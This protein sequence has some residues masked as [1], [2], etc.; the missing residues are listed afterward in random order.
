MKTI[1]VVALGPGSPDFLT[2]GAFDALKKSKNLVLRTR[3]HA[4]ADMLKK[5]G[6]AFDT[7][8]SLYDSSEDFDDFVS[9]A[10]DALTK[11]AAKKPLVY[12]VTDPMQDETVSRLIKIG[13]DQ[14]RL[15]PGV[16]L[17]GPLTAACQVVAP[18]VATSATDLV[19]VDAQRPLAVTELNSRLLAGEVKLRL[20]PYYGADAQLLFFPPSKAA[21]RSFVP[22][23]LSDLDRQDK[24]D[25]TAGFVLLPAPLT[26][27]TAFDV[28]DLMRIMRILCGRD[29]CPWDRKQTHLSLIPY[30]IEEA[31]EAAA[32]LAEEDYEQAFDELGDVLLQVA[33][34]ATVG[35][36]QGTMS[37]PDIT[38]AICSKL[39]RR[40]PHVF[41]DVSADTAEKVLVNWENIKKQERGETNTEKTLGERMEQVQKGL[42]PLLRADKVQALASKVGFDWDRAEEALEKVTEEA[43]ELRAAL[44]EGGNAMEELGDLLFSCVNTARLMGVS[45]DQSLHLA[46]E[47]F[48]KRFQWMEKALKT[49]KKDWNL[50]TS[51]EIGVY[52]ERSKT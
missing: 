4:V 29:G 43:L 31:H 27:K 46:T 38:T 1:T 52:W 11:Q 33:F 17:S 13:K 34:H 41:A 6:I 26:Q 10:V 36:E 21:T 51:K 24:Y 25:H 19:V 2:L 50:L 48:I 30:L 20:L 15:L 45:A 35:E 8:D 47:K 28:S 22:L 40:H 42:P 39:I 9:G 12:A 18:V 14:V 3:K 32:A 16:P 5:E 7:L 49:D 37:L 44:N 23:S